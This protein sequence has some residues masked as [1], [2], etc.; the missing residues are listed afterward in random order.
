M[1]NH[2]AQKTLSHYLLVDQALISGLTNMLING[3][4]AILIK[5]G[6][7]SIRFFGEE[8]VAV[9]LVITSFLLPFILTIINTQVVMRMIRSGQTFFVPPLKNDYLLT[10][11]KQSYWVWGVLLGCVMASITYVVVELLRTY[12]ANIVLNVTEYGILVAC[13][14]GFLAAITSPITAYSVMVRTQV[15]NNDFSK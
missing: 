10:I 9:G 4:I 1:A 3:L 8:G 6:S 14:A 15:L 12:L 5:Q 7:E 13:I 11:A 2:L